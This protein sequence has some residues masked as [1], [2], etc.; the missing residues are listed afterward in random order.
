M[1][2][3]TPPEED[4]E[5]LVSILEQPQEQRDY[6]PVIHRRLINLATRWVREELELVPEDQPKAVA[7]YGWI[8]DQMNWLIREIETERTLFPTN[9]RNEAVYERLESIVQA[10]QQ[11]VD[12]KPGKALA[13]LDHLSSELA[14]LL[15]K[16]RAQE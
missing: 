7:V 5:M 12:R 13:T 2:R 9:S 8:L 15:A 11:L 1:G 3:T 16:L 6:L 4:G 14:A 10:G